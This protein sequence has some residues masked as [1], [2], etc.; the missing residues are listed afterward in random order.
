MNPRLP[1]HFPCA[2]LRTDS[3]GLISAA[4]DTLAQRL[5][6][7][8]S[9][10]LGQPLETLFTTAG[11]QLIRGD[12]WPRLARQRRVDGLS[13][14][15]R[16]AFVDGGQF[17]APQQMW[18]FA[19]PSTQDTE[20]WK[21]LHIV[22][23]PCSQDRPQ[24]DQAA[25][26][27]AAALVQQ[28]ETEFLGRVS[29]ELRTPLNAILGFAQLMS[30]SAQ[31]RLSAVQ[32]QQ[33]GLIQSAGEQLRQLVEDVLDISRSGSGSFQVQLGS[34]RAAPLLERCLAL[35]GPQ[36][37]Q[38]AV[39]LAAPLVEHGLTLQ[40]DERRL[41][42]VLNNLVSNAIKYNRPGGE[43]RLRAIRQGGRACL[44]V[45]DTGHGLTDSQRCALFQPFNRLGA[46][47]TAVP[48]T[49]L[50]LVITRQ[51]VQRMGGSIQVESTPGVGSAF[52]IWLPLASSDPR[53]PEP[54]ER[55]RSM[56]QPALAGSPLGKRRSSVPHA[57]V[58]YVEDNPVNVLL[59]EAIAARRPH[60]RLQSVGTAGEALTLALKDPP[61]LLLLDQHLPDMQGHQLLAQLHL[62]P[63]LRHVPAVM[64]SADHTGPARS[65]ARAVGFCDSWGKP[66]NV[67]QVL[68]GL[69]ALCPPPA[70]APTPQVDA[71]TSESTG[72]A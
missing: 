63:R 53:H 62:D 57:Q 5:G 35:A 36:A 41:L 10:L 17:G 38:A 52:H 11:A 47:T 22:L 50:G 3:D 18:L 27:R 44:T 40:T 49:G 26:Q 70:Q 12:F 19:T 32:Q 15:L 65:A 30:T 56:R 45:Q 31:D 58:L 20:A 68:A 1:G 66:L 69:D 64:V 13:V 9:A 51:L 67:Q 61:H 28:S 55:Q 24:E 23:V 48:G 25:A 33:L 54:A 60:L 4:N 37:Q 43:V 2:L 71:S 21:A 42:Q 8:A 29:H 34:T 39:R 6:C 72:P 59:L 7:H 46:E 16:G 14:S